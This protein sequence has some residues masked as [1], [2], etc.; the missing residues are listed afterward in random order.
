MAAAGE[1]VAGATVAEPAVMAEA[2][3]RKA[4]VATAIKA[5]EAAAGFAANVCQTRDSSG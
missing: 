3:A 5:A 1:A 4:A 2:D